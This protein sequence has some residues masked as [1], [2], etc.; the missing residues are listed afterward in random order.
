[1]K[2]EMQQERLEPVSQDLFLLDLEQDMEG[3]RKFISCW[4]YRSD[5]GTF[6]VDPG[7]SATI[8]QVTSALQALGIR[9]LDYILLTHLH[10]DH[11]GGIGNLVKEFPTRVAVHEG[12]L[13]HLIDPSKLW[14]GSLSI[15]G[16]VAR[17]YG[18]IEPVPRD[19][20]M[21][22]EEIPLGSKRIK[23]LD[24]EGHAPHHRSY[25]FED[26]LFAGE[27]SGVHLDL[28]GGDFYLRPPTP[29]PFHLET[30]IN[31]LDKLSRLDFSMLCFGHFGHS[32]NREIV[33]EFRQQLLRWRD[34][35][36]KVLSKHDS[37]EDA[38]I[39]ECI[40]RLKE[41]DPLFRKIESLDKDIQA[42]E[43]Y[44]AGNSIRGFLSYLRKEHV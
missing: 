31:S 7:P 22:E 28:G 8:P 17:K 20:L 26:I 15:L 39:E 3:Y 38:L 40:N 6:L 36:E 33:A 9:K 41:Q 1:M 32:W 30:A 19:M 4:I 43:R 35:I 25:L 29:P 2:Q 11:A 14:A 13:K 12:A 24:T 5:E 42:R 37:S 34:I 18:R 44:Y 16:D 23:S 10:L 21:S 27:A